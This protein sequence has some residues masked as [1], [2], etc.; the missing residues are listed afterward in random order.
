MLRDDLGD[1]HPRED[2]AMTARL[3]EALAS[4]LLE[5]AN[6]RAARLSIHDADHFGSGDV[7]SPRDDVARVFLNEQD[8]FKGERRSCFGRR[9]IDFDDRSRRYLHLST[10][11][12]NDG[13]HEHSLHPH[14]LLRLADW[15]PGEQVSETARRRRKLRYWSRIRVP[16]IF[17]LLSVLRKV[18]MRRSISSKYDDNAG[19]VWLAL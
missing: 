17:W 19:V 15:A 10:T 3:A 1:S 6:L 13:V 18:G 14:N 12:L 7:R 16:L 11:G 4:L 5:D 8:L 2:A 9:T